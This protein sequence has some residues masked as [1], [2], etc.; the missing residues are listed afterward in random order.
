[1]SLPLAC[2]GYLDRFPESYL[3]LMPGDCPDGA[4]S[5]ASFDPSDSQATPEAHGD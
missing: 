1:M 5:C 3:E 4:S 2:I